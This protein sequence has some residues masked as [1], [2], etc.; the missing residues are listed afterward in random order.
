MKQDQAPP[1]CKET[2]DGGSGER[3]VAIDTSCTN[4]HV[5]NDDILFDCNC[6]VTRERGV[7]DSDDFTYSCFVCQKVDPHSFIRASDLIRHSVSK[8]RQYPDKAKHNKFYP[9]D[10]TD[11]RT[12][13]ADEILPCGDAS[14]R[15]KGIT[16]QQ[17][18]EI[19]INDR[20][21][22]SEKKKRLK[23]QAEAKRQEEIVK[24]GEVEVAV[25]N[26][27]KKKIF[28]EDKQEV[29][30]N[31]NRALKDAQDRRKALKKTNKD[32]DKKKVDSIPEEAPKKPTRKL[33]SEVKKM[34]RKEL[35]KEIDDEANALNKAN[36]SSN[37]KQLAVKILKMG[38][39]VHAA[40][41]SKKRESMETDESKMG[42][43][44][45]GNPPGMKKIPLLR[46]MMVEEGGK[47]VVESRD[48]QLNK[49]DIPNFVQT[50][51]E[52]HYNEDDLEP[53]SSEEEDE[54]NR[55]EEKRVQINLPPVV[56]AVP[57]Q[58]VIEIIMPVLICDD[59][60]GDK[61]D[62]NM[63]VTIDVE[64]EELAKKKEEDAAG[65]ARIREIT[66]E[67]EE[68]SRKAGL[69]TLP[70]I[71]TVLPVRG[72]GRLVKADAATPGGTTMP[73][74]LSTPGGA[75]A[76]GGL[77]NPGGTS[78]PGGTVAGRGAPAPKILF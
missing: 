62:D 43:S 58:D 2:E 26:R 51:A 3:G 16:D 70:P 41:A 20:T 8:H 55:A 4:E 46:D 33:K 56:Y 44:S 57:Y 50:F 10:G 35:Q 42:I 63:M 17:Q 37:M 77:S 24:Q 5:I 47:A 28:Q 19:K 49:V 1:E 66:A 61:S 11:H 25:R 60:E 65:I 9:A 48:P 31:L 39:E 6:S 15:K 38:P 69:L 18:E 21:K 68:S 78:V 52:V 64:A 13:K 40:Y 76:P 12:V 29:T 30:L 73:S 45:A 14:H 71:E 27:L 53:N 22:A 72:K 34:A 74:S 75:S 36:R 7:M 59:G 67:L 54:F 32:K 23:A